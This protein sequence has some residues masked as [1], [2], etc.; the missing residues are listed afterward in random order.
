MQTQL[1]EMRK[2]VFPAFTGNISLNYFLCEHQFKANWNGKMEWTE[3]LEDSWV[4]RGLI[5]GSE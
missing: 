4:Y 2:S 3:N 1:K 5:W